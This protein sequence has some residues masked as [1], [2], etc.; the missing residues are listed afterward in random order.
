MGRAWA[1][2][3]CPSSARCALVMAFVAVYL[4]RA[5]PLLS[6]CCRLHTLV[7]VAMWC[8]GCL[9][10]HNVPVDDRE[11]QNIGKHF[12][13]ACSFIHKKKCE[14]R[15]I[16]VHC[17]AGVSRSTSCVLAYLMKHEG[18]SFREGWR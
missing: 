1:G 15:R 11:G 4:F 14:G 5:E 8:G 10:Y 2:G 16:L 12:A 7:R 13:S 3:V 17:R 6:H 9:Q 18:M